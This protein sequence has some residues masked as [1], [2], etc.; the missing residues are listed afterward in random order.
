MYLEYLKPRV[1]E[2]AF[3]SE[4]NEALST[5]AYASKL[6]NIEVLL[7]YGADPNAIIAKFDEKHGS[8]IG[9]AV[10]YDN[11]DAVR[12]LLDN[13]ITPVD[14]NKVDDYRDTPLHIALDWCITSIQREMI[15]LLLKYG[16]DAS[17]S[18]GS[19]GTVLNATCQISDDDLL[20]LILNQPGVS[21]D[22]PDQLGRLP[23]HVA[24][25]RRTG[26]QRIDLLLT[27]NST[28]RSQ[29][30]QGRNI[31]H[32]AAVGGMPPLISSIL[33]ECPDLINVP[34]SDGWTPLHW[35]V[36]D[37]DTEAS[38]CLITHGANKEAK[39]HDRWTPRHVAIYHGNSDQLELLPEGE[40]ETDDEELPSEAAEK[41]TEARC[42]SCNCVRPPLTQTENH[43]TNLPLCS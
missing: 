14:L 9:L 6:E 3:S 22:A 35:A 39:T 7:E 40:D 15:E 16:A 24:A 10:A 17:I 34:D 1:S 25:D 43:L 2:D 27:D 5:A 4:I 23:I 11:I 21:P 31:L 38:Q 28:F 26:L 30:K 37:S 18:S 36:R 8:A 20:D 19:F 29:D 33:E 41:V 42:D 12:V 32:H 13:K